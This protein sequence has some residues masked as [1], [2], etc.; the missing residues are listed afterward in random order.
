VFFYVLLKK[1]FLINNNNTI[2]HKIF[3]E[4]RLPKIFLR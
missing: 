4:V 2:E 3:F 1:L